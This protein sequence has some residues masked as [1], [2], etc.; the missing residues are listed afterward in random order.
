MLMTHWT[1]FGLSQM[2]PR[3]ARERAVLRPDWQA[4]VDGRAGALREPLR[5]LTTDGAIRPGLFPLQ[6]TGVSAAPITQAALA[7]VRALSAGQRQRAVF[8]LGEPAW[9]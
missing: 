9:T 6:A 3:S 8:A 4:L 1:D 2:P 7:F 5:G